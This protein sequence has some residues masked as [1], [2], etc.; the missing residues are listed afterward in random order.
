MDAKIL[1]VAALA[2]LVVFACALT[3]LPWQA[4]LAYQ[5][6]TPAQ[7]A[8]P[9]PN[10]TIGITPTGAGPGVNEAEQTWA[11]ITVLNVEKACTATAKKEAVA[12]GYGDWVIYGCTCSALQESPE[13]K[14]Y[15]CQVSAL[16]GAHPLS[17]NC[18][19]SQRAC[20]G[21]SE[22]GTFHY[23]FAELQAMANAG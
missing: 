19:K 11:L 1:V 23:T 10:G 21:A 15:S 5:P 13:A 4:L 18:T 8:T 16:D 2:V 22:Q 12:Q 9:A 14:S 3:Q 7:N 6:Q 20:D 17:V